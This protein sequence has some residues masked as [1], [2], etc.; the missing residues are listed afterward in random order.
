MAQGGPGA[1]PRLVACAAAQGSLLLGWRVVHSPQLHPG[2]EPVVFL[3]ARWTP[4]DGADP[5]VACS[6]PG[7]PGH[8]AEPPH[9]TPSWVKGRQERDSAIDVLGGRPG[10]RRNIDSIWKMSNWGRGTSGGVKLSRFLLGHPGHLLPPAPLWVT[11]Q[12]L[13]SEALPQDCLLGPQTTST[14]PQ[15]SDR[16]WPVALCSPGSA[17]GSPVLPVLCREAPARRKVWRMLLPDLSVGWSRVT[18]AR[19]PQI[20]ICVF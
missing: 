16:K 14:R 2:K 11:A 18:A 13:S 19:W 15:A 20:I 6:W 8:T 1:G 4:A 3:S 10:S 5:A 17:T 12:L 9:L 7:S